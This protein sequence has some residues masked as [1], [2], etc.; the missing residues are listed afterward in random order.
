MQNSSKSLLTE[1]KAEEAKALLTAYNPDRQREVCRDL[2]SCYL[3]DYPTLAEIRSA[4]GDN[5]P[6]A[7]LTPQIINLAAFCGI[8][9]K[10]DKQL[11]R[12]TAEVIAAEYYYLKVSELMLFFHRFKAGWYGMFYGSIDPLVITSALVKFVN[13]RNAE[14]GREEQRQR[15]AREETPYEKQ[16]KYL[17]W[18]EVNGKDPDKQETGVEYFKI[19]K[20]KK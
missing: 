1:A 17:Q 10:L 12:E 11:I 9:E 4:Y 13:E 6:T 18:C 20:N 19:L 16:A 7:W 15:K 8:R 3:G 5:I 2:R 14:I